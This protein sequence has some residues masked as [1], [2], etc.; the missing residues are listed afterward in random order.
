MKIVHREGERSDLSGKR[1]NLVVAY[2]FSLEVWVSYKLIGGISITLLYSI[3]TVLY[4]AYGG[5][6]QDEPEDREAQDAADIKQ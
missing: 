6:L 4:L 3:L 1:V 2:N 5:Y